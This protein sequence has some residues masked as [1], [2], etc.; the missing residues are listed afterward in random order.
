MALA[1]L[2]AVMLGYSRVPYAAAVDV[3]FFKVFGKLH[4]TKNFPYVSLL[5]LAAFTLVFSLLFRMKHIIDG[6]LA[7]QIMVHF[8][9]QALG[10][11]LLR[12]R[13]GI[14]H[15]HYKMPFYPLPVI[16]AIAMWLFVFYAAGLTIILSFL[17]VPGSGLVMYFILAK[18]QNQWPFRSK[19]IV[20]PEDEIDL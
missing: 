10:V 2:F 11:G 4:P 8:I 16:F 20:M 19:Q 6:I 12:K 15:L 18:M 5:V 3:A 17:L 14:E 1:S 7:M 9:G 13:N